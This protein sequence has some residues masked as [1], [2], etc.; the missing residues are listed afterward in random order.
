MNNVCLFGRIANDL[1][2]KTTTSGKS[3]CNF[4][5]AINKFNNDGTNF[6]PCRVWNK[7][8]ENLVR[9]KKKGDQIV[10][11]GSVETNDYEKEGQK[12]K[13]VYINANQIHY[14]AFNNS[15]SNNIDNNELKNNEENI[16]ETENISNYDDEVE[17]SFDDLPF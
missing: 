3:I 11:V 10:I 12:R 4:N 1:E 15:Q 16:F 13:Y 8:A 7:I 5:I 9:Y 6:I 14:V 17:I 2:L